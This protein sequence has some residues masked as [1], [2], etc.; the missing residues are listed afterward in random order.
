M[1]LDHLIVEKM[2][3]TDLVEEDIESVIRFGAQTLFDENEEESKLTK[4]YTDTEIEGILERKEKKDESEEASAEG[5][6]KDNAFGFEKV[7]AHKDSRG[8][9]EEPV[10]GEEGE[11]EKEDGD[12]QFW[13]KL[14]KD[15]QTHLAELEKLKSEVYGR[16]K[17]KKTKVT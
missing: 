1:V 12:P 6:E 11:K 4:K 17:R 13:E 10:P 8:G 5:D 15:R 7:W 14:L 9:S 16:G 3:D 2:D